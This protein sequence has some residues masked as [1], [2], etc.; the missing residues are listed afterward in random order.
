MKCHS[1]CD[2]HIE[3][4][5]TD[6]LSAL[7]KGESVK[8]T[9]YAHVLDA[10]RSAPAVTSGLRVIVYTTCSFTSLGALGKSTVRCL[11]AAAGNLKKRAVAAARTWHLARTG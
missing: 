6:P 7:K 2:S 11:N 3:G 10:G 8:E 5:A 9:S 1:L 4:E